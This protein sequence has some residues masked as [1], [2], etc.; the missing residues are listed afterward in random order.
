MRISA[1]R[2]AKFYKKLSH[3]V[4]GTKR[5]KRRVIRYGLITA[6]IALL[7]GV[8]AFVAT[9][10]SSSG[11]VDIGS[12]QFAAAAPAKTA[13]TGPLDQLS[14]VDIAVNIARTT[15]MAEA[16]AVTNQSDSARIT[17][18]VSVS[19]TALAAK[20]QVI[21][22]SVKTADDIQIYI[23]K[24]GDTISSLAAQFNVTSDAIRW[25]NGLTGDRLRAGTEVVIPPIEGIAY[26]V[27]AG[28]TPESLAAKF[29]ANAAQ[30]IAF[31]D[32]EIG[33]LVVGK[34]IVI[35]NGRVAPTVSPAR[36]FLA[37]YG[38]NTYDPGW[39]TYYAAARSGAPGG[40]GNANTWARYARM[41][42]GWT[43]SAVPVPG[44][45]AQT[46]SGR[47]GHVGIVEDV[48]V[49]NGQYYIKYSDMNGLAG[50]NR[51]G[52]SDWVPAIGKYQNFIYR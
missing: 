10:A 35:P 6:N 20:P 50:F 44:A 47:W 22:D 30:I 48:K 5:A 24:E 41:T 4:V 7:G 32:A 9:S 1:D 27:K 17:N 36:V 28:D 37:R 33:G 40:W 12:G 8:A 14:S 23:A 21:G 31:N 43:V 26:L 49:E 51:V 11:S 34:R 3:R 15:G 29:G 46:S 38:Y 45:I 42:P 19:D 16:T 2:S 25:S 39:C 18:E 13:V 52:Y